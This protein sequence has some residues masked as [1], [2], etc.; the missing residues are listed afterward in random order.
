[1]QLDRALP[2]PIHSRPLTP[3]LSRNQ[4]WTAVLN[5]PSIRL[6][7]QDIC[8]VV[9]HRPLASPP[10]IFGSAFSRGGRTCRLFLASLTDICWPSPSSPRAWYRPSGASRAGTCPRPPSGV[11]VVRETAGR[12]AVRPC[13]NRQ[14][15][16]EHAHRLWDAPRRA[17][18]PSPLSADC[19]Q[20]PQARQTECARRH[21]RNLF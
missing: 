9:G 20:H 5:E 17:S 8:R 15:N 14:T 11:V 2:Y 10:I 16:A 7:A 6:S 4:T 13:S 12:E 18:P 3:L 1:M 19:H 21:D